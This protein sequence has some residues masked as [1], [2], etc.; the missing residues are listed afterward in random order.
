MG[1]CTFPASWMWS[2]AALG[3]VFAILTA[4]TLVFRHR[5]L[6]FTATVTL[7]LG[8][9]LLIAAVAG[10]VYAQMKLGDTG[11]VDDVLET[12]MR[13]QAF[14]L[15]F[16]QGGVAGLIPMFVG[17]IGLMVARVARRRAATPTPIP[18]AMPSP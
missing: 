7:V 5:H 10:P 2:F 4:A 18:P 1:L 3:V 16:R 15:C 12:S 17:S 8:V 13:W 9:A 11:G 14:R 6:R